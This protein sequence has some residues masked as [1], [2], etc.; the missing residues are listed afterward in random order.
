[1]ERARQKYGSADYRAAAGIMRAVFVR[2]VGERYD[3]ELAALRCPVEFVWGEDDPDVPVEV[4]RAALA[5]VPGATLTLCPGAGHLTPLTV[6][7]ELRAAV[8]RALARP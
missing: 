4:A 3:D 5:L 1:M 7:G 2:L 6:P 8:D